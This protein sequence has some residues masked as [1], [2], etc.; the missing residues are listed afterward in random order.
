MHIPKCAGTSLERVIWRS[1]EHTPQCLFGGLLNIYYNQYQTGG[2]QHLKALQIRQHVGRSKFDAYFKFAIVRNPFDKAV[3]QFKYIRT[4]GHLLEYI[5]MSISDSFL[6]Y[7][8]K[9]RF[10]THVQWDSQISFIFDYS[11]RQLVDYVGRF[12]RLDQAF[13]E[14]LGPI[15]L[16][17]PVPHSMASHDRTGF[18]DFYDEEARLLVEDMYRDDLEVL[19]YRFDQ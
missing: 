4:K 3:S 2:L 6:T 19:G 1:E 13:S 17:A 8:R 5:G 7:L 12:E 9:I 10:R 14:I 16:S 11:G 15:G 18:R